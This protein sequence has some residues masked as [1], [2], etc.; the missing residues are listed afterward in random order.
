LWRGAHATIL[1]PREG[2]HPAW[3]AAFLIVFVLFPVTRIFD[4]AFADEAGAFTLASLR[5]FFTDSVYLR[6]LWRSMVLGVVAVATASLVVSAARVSVS[7]SGQLRGSKRA[8]RSSAR[9]STSEI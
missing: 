5:E 3:Q 2:I 9:G 4:D 7:A 6:S 8:L 1:P